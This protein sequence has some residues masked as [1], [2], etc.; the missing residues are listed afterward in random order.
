M[1]SRPTSV[2]R[3]LESL[4]QQ[5]RCDRT[6]DT[7]EGQYKLSGIDNNGLLSS[8]Q[9]SLLSYVLNQ[10]KQEDQTCRICLVLNINGFHL[11]ALI[12]RRIVLFLAFL[13]SCRRSVTWKHGCMVCS[14]RRHTMLP[15]VLIH[16]IK[17]FG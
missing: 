1:R 6:M 14:L 15:N 11:S 3:K 4:S 5:A 17:Q 9:R 12:R 16:T 2:S 10:N 8:F 7:V 13:V